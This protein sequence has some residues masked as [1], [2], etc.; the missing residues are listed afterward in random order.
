MGFQENIGF[1][2]NASQQS[3]FVKLPITHNVKNSNLIVYMIF[4]G[5]V[6]HVYCTINLMFIVQ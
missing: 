2:I 5:L 4:I 1:L 6:V 3:L